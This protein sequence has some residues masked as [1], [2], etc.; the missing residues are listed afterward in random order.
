MSDLEPGHLPRACLDQQGLWEN[1]GFCAWFSSSFCDKCGILIQRK[2]CS[3]C[4]H[5]ESWCCHL[6]HPRMYRKF[7]FHS[8]L[9]WNSLGAEGKPRYF[10]MSQC[11]FLP[12]FIQQGFPVLSRAA[13]AREGCTLIALSLVCLLTLKL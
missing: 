9:E 11:S 6:Y 4:S 3:A 12:L 10:L 2:P 5:L 1:L 8:G 7:L 13:S